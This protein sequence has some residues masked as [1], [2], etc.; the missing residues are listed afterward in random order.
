MEE[1]IAVRQSIASYLLVRKLWLLVFYI[2]LISVGIVAFVHGEAWSPFEAAYVIIQIVT[3]IGYGD[4]TVNTDPMK[5]FVAVY[6]SVCLLCAT[7]AIFLFRYN[8]LQTRQEQIKERVRVM[9]GRERAE[10]GLLEWAARVMRRASVATC[11]SV[12]MIAFGTIFFRWTE[13]CVCPS[14]TPE[15]TSCINTDF[16]T[17]VSTGGLVMTYVDSFYMSVITLTTIGFGDYV[18]RTHWGRYVSCFWMLIGVVIKLNFIDKLSNWFFGLETDDLVKEVDKTGSATF[19]KVDRRGSGLLSRGEFLTFVL[20]Q[21][22]I[23]S[24]EL[25]EEMDTLYMKMSSHDKK[26]KQ[27]QDRSD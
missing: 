3:T 10:I 13:R 15:A 8:V 16:A 20:M 25:L 24:D 1:A 4:I 19:H 7:Y 12:A 22:G 5:I 11:L 26:R 27:K 18:P 14:Q 2:M 9:G 21:H 17:C 23:V 6:S